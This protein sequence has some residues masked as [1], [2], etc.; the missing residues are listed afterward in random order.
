M[1]IKRIFSQALVGLA[2]SALLS[3]GLAFAAIDDYTISGDDIA[4]LPDAGDASVV[5]A[6]TAITL[7]D[8]GGDDFTNDPEVLTFTI[9]TGSYPS[10]EFD[11][12]VTAATIAG[13]CNFDTQ[14][15][16]VYS[17]SD[18]VATLTI[19][20]GTN[21]GA[22]ELITIAGLK[23]E[24]NYAVAAPGAAAL[25]TVDNTTT[26]SGSAVGGA[27]V[28]YA[29]AVGDLTSTNVEPSELTLATTTTNT[30]SFTT[31]A[32]MASGTQLSIT[33]PSG[34]DVTG[35]TGTAGNLSGLTGTWTITSPGSQIVKAVKSGGSTDT[36]GAKSFTVAGIINP[37]TEGT[38]GT[39][40]ILI[41][42]GADNDQE[43]DAAISADMIIGGGGS[44]TPTVGDVSGLTVSGNADGI[45]LTWTD[46]AGDD[47]N[48][49]QILRGV[50]P[51]PVSGSLYGLVDIGVQTFTDTDVAEGDK[52][53]Y[54]V[55]AVNG[56]EYGTLTSEVSI[57]VA[58]AGV[59]V[60]PVTETPEPTVVEEPTPEP[61][62]EEPAPEFSDTDSHWAQTEIEFMAE[63]GVVEGNP[64]GTFLPDSD[65]DRAQAA[66][67]IH[68]IMGLEE[69]TAPLDNPFTDVPKGAWYA[70]YI[71]DLKAEGAIDGNPDGTFQPSEFIN[72]A[73]FL[74]MA[75][76]AY[77]NTHNV[78][79][80]VMT[81]AY[82]DL[83]TS[84]WYA[85]T[86]SQATGLGFIEGS[87]CEDGRCF[88]ADLFTTRAEATAILYRMFSSEL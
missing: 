67:L 76:N 50:D 60:E 46:P 51:L 62:S 19:S 57:T 15:S 85:Q 66:V 31:G 80:V 65:L 75:M 54:Q 86:V 10:V 21:C 39:Y 6:S 45:E 68:R 88:Y 16:L 47:S 87:I 20:G 82:A 40:T 25:F 22:G 9:N 52:I 18:T 53:T 48:Q 34:F 7:T 3:A 44:F 72:R 37:V 4:A 70:G 71:A 69:P 56:G 23:V 30:I 41:E 83:D 13:D 1:S 58:A 17:S 77:K 61:I 2:L 28:N 49:I 26:S 59:V 14:D 35:A 36:G 43:T 8:A 11:S 64:D 24:T 79:V 81:D 5:I 32:D 12:T 63:A 78:G 29:V 33:Y 55:R 73:E 42:D 38:T 74:Q 27:S 84:A